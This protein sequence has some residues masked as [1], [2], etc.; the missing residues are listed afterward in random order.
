MCSQVYKF[1]SSS[2]SPGTQDEWAKDEQE[3]H[4]QDE[5]DGRNKEGEENGDH[6]KYVLANAQYCI[7]QS[8]GGEG[9]N[10][11]RCCFGRM[12]HKCE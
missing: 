2:T 3:Q 10:E 8:G 9:G 6:D 4:H 11:P 5:H 1:T 12:T 7:E